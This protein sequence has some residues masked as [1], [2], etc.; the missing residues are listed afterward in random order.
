MI[1]IDENTAVVSWLN[2]LERKD[3]FGYVRLDID[4]FEVAGGLDTELILI[5]DVVYLQMSKV[6]LDK[7][8][9]CA[10]V[11]IF[12]SSDAP[13]VNYLRNILSVIDSKMNQELVINQILF[14]ENQFRVNNILKSQLITINKELIE[15]GGGVESQIVRIKKAYEQNVPKRLSEFKGVNI[16]SK[17]AAGENMGGEFFDMFSTE[18]KIFLLMSSTS[19]YLAS[20]SILQ[21]FA[22]MKSS[23][24]ISKKSELQTLESIRA[25][26]VNMNHGKS[27]EIEVQIATCILDLQTLK[28]S[29]H[30]LGNFQFLSSNTEHNK[31]YSNPITSDL[32]DAY[33]EAQIVRGERILF[34]SPGFIHNWNS[35]ESNF[36]LEELV[37]NR[38]LRSLDIL[39]EAFFNLK[40]NSTTEF[41]PYDASAVLLEVKDNVMLQV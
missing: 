16:L 39:D 17:Y 5:E 31:N 9:L 30:I 21:C 3:E 41:L 34:N 29:G 20:S 26:V 40:K 37:L 15:I 12:K 32:E 13:L 23:G 18:N 10:G 24:D 11:I 8:S 7:L 33:F 38:K 28:I 2:Q 1:V 19:S 14:F 36:L 6:L 22:E 25:E 4:T 35:I 27:K